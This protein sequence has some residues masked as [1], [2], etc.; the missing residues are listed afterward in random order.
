MSIFDPKQVVLLLNDYQITCF[1][2]KGTPIQFTPGAPAGAWT[3]GLDGRGTFVTDPDKSGT[4]VIQL[5]QHCEDNRWLSQQKSL[6]EN[7]IKSF[8]PFR[9][10]IR[11]LL[12]EDLIEAAKGY[13][14]DLPPYARGGSAQMT[15]WTIVF[16][17]H[18]SR[19][20]SGFGN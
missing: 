17:S 18:T 15:P 9:L 7:S 11:D 19:L 4:L 13:F 5:H 20:E 16:E 14:T 6:Q 2:D 3:M 1:G 12:N 10:M 8:V